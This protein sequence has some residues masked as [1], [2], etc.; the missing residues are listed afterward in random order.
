MNDPNPTSTGDSSHESDAS[1]TEQA[2]SKE[3]RPPAQEAAD[4][5][6]REEERQLETGEENPT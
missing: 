5:A 3:H 4:E 2:K 6:Q 1:K